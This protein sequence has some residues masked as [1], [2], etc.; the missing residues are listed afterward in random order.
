MTHR[1]ARA[2]RTVPESYSRLSARSLIL[3]PSTV[4]TNK[5]AI[6]EDTFFW[7]GDLGRGYAR[8]AFATQYAP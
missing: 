2:V 5:S 1:G 7:G 6:A 8:F 4:M 3:Y